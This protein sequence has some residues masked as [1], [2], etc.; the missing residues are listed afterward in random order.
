MP[1][2]RFKNLIPAAKSDNAEIGQWSFY[3]I[4]L[5]LITTLLRLIFSVFAE[6][7]YEEA[8]Y[9]CY[10]AHLDLSYFD[11]PPMVGWLIYAFSHLGGN[12]E[13]LVRVPTILLFAGTLVVLFRLAEAMFS[14]KT[15]F[16]ACAAA[17]CLPAFEW[18]SMLMLPEAPLLFFWALGMLYGYKLIKEEKPVYWWGVGIATGL[19]L[20]SKYPALLIPAAPILYL[21]LA[22]RWKLLFNVHFAGAAAVALALFSPV[23]I[24][25]SQHEWCSFMF[26]GV[27]RF[28]ERFTTDLTNRLWGTLLNQAVVLSPG[29][30]ALIAWGLWAGWRRR[31]E[32]AVRYLLCASLPLLAIV[33][34]VSCRRLV[35]MNWPLP[36]Y[37]A[38]III[39]G[40][41]LENRDLLQRRKA[42]MALVFVPAILISLLPLI[43]TML[44]IGAL[45]RMNDFRGWQEVSKA[46]IEDLGHMP[47]QEAVIIA[48]TSYQISS[49]LAFYTKRPDIV[50]CSNLWCRPGIDEGF[51]DAKGFTYWCSNE[52]LKGCDAI[53]VAYDELRSDGKW[54]QRGEF[55]EKQC[56]RC[57]ESFAKSETL[58]VFYGGKPLRRYRIYLAHNYLGLQP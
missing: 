58:T 20:L 1:S 30:L 11:H 39:I 27:S 42:L 35:L 56:S 4:Q 13:M 46:V 5:V 2:L 25:N 8:Y 6:L 40:S 53:I 33:L 52:E 47:S 37:L 16:L 26:Q 22:K 36:S 12:Q 7:K 38:A 51:K 49:E 15:A 41:E 28:S 29:G 9:W 18:Y 50:T 24:W 10:A 44:P 54:H 55:E 34:A 32:P 23:I 19:G 3:F 14:P 17:C 43:G 21:A 48:G 31:Q 57:F 45:N